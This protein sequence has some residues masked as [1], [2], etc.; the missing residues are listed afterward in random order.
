MRKLLYLLL[1]TSFAF[2]Q[3]SNKIQIDWKGLSDVEYG[4][5]KFSLPLFSYEN[6]QFNPEL[7]SLSFVKKIEA[8]G[9]INEKS[10]TLSNV[11]YTPLSSDEL[12]AVQVLKIPSE[13]QAKIE[14]ESARGL[15]KGLLTFSP[16]IK[17]DGAFYKVTSLSYDFA[18]DPNFNKN[19]QTATNYYG[20]VNAALSTGNWFRFYVEKSGI[21]K[22]SK[23]F[24]QSLGLDLNGVNPKKIKIFG[25]PIYSSETK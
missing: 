19:T 16:I 10:L 2:G 13:I 17:K 6:F 25:I 20:I 7:S 23:S 22:L 11:E 8:S 4:T 12:A 5:T 3:N 21:Y 15:I 9:W 14:N 1:V 18:L 24:I